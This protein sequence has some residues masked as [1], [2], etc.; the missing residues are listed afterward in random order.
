M[1]KDI[2]IADLRNRINKYVTDERQ[3]GWLVSNLNQLKTSFYDEKKELLKDKIEILIEILDTTEDNEQLVEKLKNESRLYE[4]NKRSLVKESEVEIIKIH[5]VKQQKTKVTNSFDD[6]KS[7]TSNNEKSENQSSPGL[8]DSNSNI[9]NNNNTICEVQDPNK[10]NPTKGNKPNL[11]K[12]DTNKYYYQIHQENLSSIYDC[13]LICPTKY[14]SQRTQADIQEKYRSYLLISD[15]EILYND[16]S[17]KQMLLELHLTID[18]HPIQL[19][20]D[21]LFLF[22]KPLPISRISKII[23]SDKVY[24]EKLMGLVASDAIS[25]IPDVIGT[26]KTNIPKKIVTL[27]SKAGDEKL[28]FIEKLRVFD[29]R[30]GALAYMKNANLF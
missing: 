1:R 20:N 28:D 21:G 29:K 8:F 17:S 18:E 22:D 30:L 25:F 27:D 5:S 14:D 15:S 12:K 23:Y 3:V 6:K 10:S 7:K 2:T 13:G 19:S 9:D 16:E 24:W 4:N 26:Y 11:I